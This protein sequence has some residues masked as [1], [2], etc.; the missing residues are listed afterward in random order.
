MIKS[1]LD[2]HYTIRARLAWEEE[3]LRVRQIGPSIFE[4]FERSSELAQ[5]ESDDNRLQLMYD[6]VHIKCKCLP[7]AGTPTRRSLFHFLRSEVGVI[8]SVMII[9]DASLWTLHS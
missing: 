9:R 2:G 1:I 8:C 4:N 6:A 7:N 3:G 5:R